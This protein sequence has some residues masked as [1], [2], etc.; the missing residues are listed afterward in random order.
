MRTKLHA[1][2]VLSSTVLI[3][4]ALTACGSTLA[5][6][7]KTTYPQSVKQRASDNK[8]IAAKLLDDGY[9]SK[10]LYKK[11]TEQIDSAT[12]KILEGVDK[13]NTEEAQNVETGTVANFAD[14]VTA[15][16]IR[17]PDFVD[18]VDD[19]GTTTTEKVGSS[20]PVVSKVNKNGGKTLSSFVISNYIWGQHLQKKTYKPNTWNYT[21]SKKSIDFFDSCEKELKDALNEKFKLPVYVFDA[22]KITSSD[23]SIDQVLA[24]VNQSVIDGDISGV[25]NYFSPLKDED[26]KQVNLMDK[27]FKIYGVS[28]DNTDNKYNQPGYDLMITQQLWYGSSRKNMH[29]KTVQVATLRFNEF[30]E[31]AVNKMRNT[32]YNNGKSY[33][34]QTT[35]SGT[36]AA[37]LL[38]YPVSVINKLVQDSDKKTTIYAKTTIKSG[39]GVNIGTGKLISYKK[40]EDGKFTSQGTVLDT[41]D[42]YLTTAF[43]Q[44]S[45]KAGNSSLVAKGFVKAT[46]PTCGNKTVKAI[47]PQLVLR[48]YLEATWAPQSVEYDE[49]LVVFGRK[50]RF[51]T[52]KSFWK[53]DETFK[54]D[55]NNYN[56][57]KLKY[58]TK[59]ADY[60]AYFVDKDG[61]KTDESNIL[62][63]YDILDIDKLGSGNATAPTDAPTSGAYIIYSSETTMKNRML[64]SNT[65]S[66]MEE[67]QSKI[68]TSADKDFLKNCFGDNFVQKLDT[69]RVLAGQRAF[70][71]K[72]KS[73][74]KALRKLGGRYS[75]S[76]SSA[77]HDTTDWSKYVVAHFPEASIQPS[78]T[79]CRVSS[80]ETQP[81]QD[82]LAS[83]TEITELKAT[84]MFPGDMIGAVDKSN[85][86]KEVQRFYCIATTKGM[87][88]SALYSD[89]I[90]STSKD[91]SLEW[92]NNY[93][94]KH[95]YAYTIN[96]GDVNDYLTEN[97]QFEL[98]QSGVVILDLKTVAAIQRL[99]DQEYELQQANGI[100]TLFI[101]IGY[102]LIAL[103]MIL[104][105]AWVID[106][107]VDVGLDLVSKLTFGH[108]IAIQYADEIPEHDTEERS[109]I[110][111]AR[112]FKKTFLII[113]LGIILIRVDENAIVLM[114][115][116]VFGKFGT[117]AEEMI[118]GIYM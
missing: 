46:I 30:D 86:G 98:S 33:Y 58:N 64:V 54:L 19:N 87:F 31:E 81:K 85:N 75:D 56:S 97:Y 77:T 36:T 28:K 79:Q 93:L 100:R 14:S 59:N 82:K 68:P 60:C 42:S 94:K 110:T 80:G 2:I 69:S 99:Y 38:E 73:L 108:W 22:T 62:H 39:I 25:S 101:M 109:Y 53:K 48:D 118:R 70:D 104:M 107:H 18:I 111:F 7:V 114:F 1:L 90:N 78:S 115:I 47:V 55:G 24:A 49:K 112:L 27:N 35:S 67:I 66:H 11:I 89:W 116:D 95:G 32:I 40:D 16:Y 15:V 71:K 4:L 50:I 6:Y 88:D 105:L 106:T 113:T 57:Y 29:Q 74:K 23:K 20:W 91:A 92:W 83:T 52:T 3:A 21:K 41:G 44:S 63:I 102:L 103:S 26:G 61:K 9:I 37:Y 65:V 8:D 72:M 12:E 10:K 43:N 5:T 96:H 51:R 34:F 117:W 76:Q 84:E 45:K 17:H 13:I